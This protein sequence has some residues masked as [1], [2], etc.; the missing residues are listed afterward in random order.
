MGGISYSFKKSGISL[1][2]GYIPSFI[3]TEPLKNINTLDDLPY[4][5]YFTKADDV[6][7][8]SESRKLRIKFSYK[9]YMSFKAF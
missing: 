7:V 3:N 9:Y 4:S 1:D 2:V 8:V 5:E 6:I